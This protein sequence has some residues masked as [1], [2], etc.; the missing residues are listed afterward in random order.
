VV[1][2]SPAENSTMT[3]GSE[4]MED[5][6]I[7]VVGEGLKDN[8]EELPLTSDESQRAAPGAQ[9]TARIPAR[10]RLRARHRDSAAAQSG[11]LPLPPSSPPPCALAVR[12]RHHPTCQQHP[13]GALQLL[14]P[15]RAHSQSFPPNAA[16]NRSLLA[17]T[18][19]SLLLAAE[20]QRCLRLLPCALPP[21]GRSALSLFTPGVSETTDSAWNR[22]PDQTHQRC[23]ERVTSVSYCGGL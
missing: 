1:L 13:A 7:D 16:G 5:I 17:G 23:L 15:Q 11:H 12:P 6:V 21:G 20:P 14:L 8:G 22:G 18:V 19:C 2:A 3:L 9:R 10:R 4:I